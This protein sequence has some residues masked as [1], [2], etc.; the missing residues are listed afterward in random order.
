MK[1]DKSILKARNELKRIIVAKKDIKKGIKFSEDNLSIKRGFN[2]KNSL[3]PVMIYKIIGKK[4]L[5]SVKKDL[6]LTYSHFR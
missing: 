1:L 5:K 2:T 4:S 3:P 6:G